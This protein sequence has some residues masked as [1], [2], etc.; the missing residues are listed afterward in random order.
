MNQD[1]YFDVDL[2]QI[3]ASIDDKKFFHPDEEFCVK[4]LNDILGSK[5]E[6]KN[7][8]RALT[9]GNL[10]IEYQVEVNGIVQPSGISTSKAEWWMMKVGETCQLYPISFLRYIFDNREDLD[11]NIKDNGYQKNYVGY[12]LILPLNKVQ[13]LLVKYKTYQQQESLKRIRKELF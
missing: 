9:T 2:S 8:D 6:I 4:M 13:E 12:G 1:K 5:I 7:Q 11:L 3:D 10:F